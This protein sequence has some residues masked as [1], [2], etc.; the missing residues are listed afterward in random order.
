MDSTPAP[1]ILFEDKNVMV[2]SKPVGLL[3]QGAK[4]GEP[5]LVDWLRG[6]L[7]RHYVGLIHRL[8]R[9]VSGAMVVAKRTKAARRLTEALQKGEIRRIY[10]GWVRGDLKTERVLR[11]SL[12]K[13][14]ALN[15]VRVVSSLDPKGK[16]AVLKVRPLKRRKWKGN[17]IMLTQFELSSGR[18]HQI[19][20]QCAAEKFSILGDRKY[21]GQS[22]RWDWKVLGRPALHASRLRFPHP[23][24]G[25]ILEFEA[26]LPEDMKRIGGDVKTLTRK[27]SG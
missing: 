18:S 9:N 14:A 16:K 21:G 15:E 7:G 1:Q 3:S 22:R 13:D 4:K 17:A 8:Y 10:V 12:V 19:R 26:T 24:S 5:N 6:Y 27:A 23:I 2:L 20:V 25:E 11:H